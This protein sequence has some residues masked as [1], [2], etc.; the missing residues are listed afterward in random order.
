MS[1][2]AIAAFLTQV[3]E[4]SN[5]Q[6]A[7]VEFAAHRGFRFTTRELQDVDLARLSGEFVAV[8][9]EEP[10]QDVDDDD[11]DP[12]FGIIEVPA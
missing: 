8:G 1:R 11:L 3:A 5:L 7:L 12:G 9:A 2:D 4:D 10:V 6:H